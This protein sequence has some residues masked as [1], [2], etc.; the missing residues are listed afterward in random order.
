MEGAYVTH[1]G[2]SFLQQRSDRVRCLESELVSDSAGTTALTSVA[3]EFYK[4]KHQM[5]TLVQ[6]V[7]TKKLRE[8]SEVVKIPNQH[9]D[10]EFTV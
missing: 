2:N 4:P 1:P 3:H 9:L 6:L 7:I 5:L 10:L 8:C